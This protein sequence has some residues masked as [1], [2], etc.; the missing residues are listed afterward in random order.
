[1]KRVM[2]FRPNAITPEQKEMLEANDIIVIEL[3][4]PSDVVTIHPIDMVTGNDDKNG[5]EIFEGD[6]VR[7]VYKESEGGG[8]YSEHKVF[9]KVYFDPHWG[10]KFDCKDGTQ[11]TADYWQKITNNDCRAVEIIGSIH[12]HPELLKPTK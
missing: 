1:M 3:L 11:R 9:G 8:W 12:T 2:I 7:A 6:I 4:R 10:V 5:K